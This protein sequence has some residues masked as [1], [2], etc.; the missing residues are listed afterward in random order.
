MVPVYS[1]AKFDVMYQLS[2][3]QDSGDCE[4]YEC[5]GYHR[6]P[7]TVAEFGKGSQKARVCVL[8]K[9]VVILLLV[10]GK[11]DGEGQR[12]LPGLVRE[13]AGRVQEGPMPASG[14]VGWF[15]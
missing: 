12:R 1:R 14:F 6:Y 5:E 11:E 4:D 9:K 15:Q 13:I 8:N 2:Y 3:W 10:P 7:C